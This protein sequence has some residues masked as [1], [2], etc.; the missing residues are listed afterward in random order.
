VQRD[1]HH[2]HVRRTG[3]R[4]PA[5][6][7]VEVVQVAPQG[8]GPGLG[9]PPLADQ[10]RRLRA[11]GLRHRVQ[12]GG[13]QSLQAGG[14][15]ARAARVDAGVVRLPPGRRGP[16]PAGRAA[17]VEGAGPAQRLRSVVAVEGGQDR[18]GHQ[19]QASDDRLDAQAESGVA[20][21]VAIAEDDAADVAGPEAGQAALQKEAEAGGRVGRVGEDQVGALAQAA[22]Q[23]HPQVRVERAHPP[24]MLRGRAVDVLQ[25]P[26]VHVHHGDVR[27]GAGLGERERGQVV[28]AEAQHGGAGE[29]ERLAEEARAPGRRRRRG[30][31]VVEIAVGFGQA[32][33]QRRHGGLQILRLYGGRRRAAPGGGHR[34]FVPGE[35]A[36]AVAAHLEPRAQAAH[37]ALDRPPRGDVVPDQLAHG[38]P[39]PIGEGAA[40]A[41]DAARLDAPLGEQRSG[42]L[43]ELGCR[44]ARPARWGAW[45]LMMRGGRGGRWA[46][47]G[48]GGPPV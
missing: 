12:G 38:V 13:G 45:A 43:A 3:E 19:V 26:L 36:D 44:R 22:R 16:G 33:H 31:N 27:P 11:G 40:D 39:A 1:R 34:A 4:R 29:V 28:V 23:L 42:C 5:P 10:Q 30:E 15:R 14:L 20:L 17:D 48:G 25:D 32:A 37:D 8:P 47:G 6:G 41:A 7:G 21:A 35:D 9:R 2:A 24:A 18:L 46:A